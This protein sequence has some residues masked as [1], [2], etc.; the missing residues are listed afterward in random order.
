MKVLDKSGLSYLWDVIK[1]Y[2][3]GNY[4]LLPSFVYNA[5][6]SSVTVPSGQWTAVGSVELSPGRYMGAA[7]VQI[8]ANATG[9]R[10]LAFAKNS[11][12]ISRVQKATQAGHSG[13]GNC[14]NIP[15]F[16]SVSETTT[17]NIYVYQNSGSSLLCYPAY[18]FL[19]FP[20]AV[21]ESEV[22]E[23]A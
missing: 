8:A 6:L 17:F 1:G 11:D 10:I 4:Q 23:D 19:N 21:T 3:S 16:F 15:R 7:Y 5:S 2:I 13:T 22:S 20:Y 12:S 18:S 9:Y 14:L